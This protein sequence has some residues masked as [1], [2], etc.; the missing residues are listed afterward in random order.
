ANEPVGRWAA[1]EL[2]HATNHWRQHFRG[3]ARVKDDTEVTDADIAAHNLVLWGD[4]SA[5]KVLARIAAQLPVRWDGQRVQV[6]T[7]EFPAAQHAV[8]LIYPNP[9]NPDRYV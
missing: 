9:L 6:G 2:A 8:I 1:S 3:D 5:N 4:P 7:Q